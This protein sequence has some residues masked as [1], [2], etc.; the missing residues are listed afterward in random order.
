LEASAVSS[1]GVYDDVRDYIF[2]IEMVKVF[3]NE[4]LAT[5]GEILDVEDI[6]HRM[7]DEGIKAVAGSLGSS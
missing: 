5:V 4:I 2:K 1:G 3:K 7:A 6:L